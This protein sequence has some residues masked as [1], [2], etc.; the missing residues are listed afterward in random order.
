MMK[1]LMKYLEKMKIFQK[2]R[3]QTI[4]SSIKRLLELE[5]PD[6]EFPEI[7]KSITNLLSDV[8]SKILSDFQI[9]KS[10]PQAVFFYGSNCDT[11]FRPNK[12]GT[13]I[14]INL[15]DKCFLDYVFENRKREQF[16]I[17]AL[18]MLKSLIAEK[19]V[20]S[21][22]GI[23][24]S[25]VFAYENIPPF[26][27]SEIPYSDKQSWFSEFLTFYFR[28]VNED[29][30]TKVSHCFD[31]LHELAHVIEKSNPKKLEKFHQIADEE[32]NRYINSNPSLE[33][34]EGYAK[35]LGWA[36]E[37]PIELYDEL[38]NTN[39]IRSIER[40]PYMKQEVICDLFAITYL[41]Q[42][43]KKMNL[44]Y[45]E[46]LK[47][48]HAKLNAHHLR[49]IVNRVTDQLNLTEVLHGDSK[50]NVKDLDV[51][52]GDI[53]DR[54][55]I[56]TD[57]ML[58]FAIDSGNQNLVEKGHLHIDLV[59]TLNQA[60]LEAFLLPLL[61]IIPNFIIFAVE[62]L[63]NEPYR[64]SMEYFIKKLGNKNLA[65]FVKKPSFI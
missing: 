24:F 49:V 14:C 53:F 4:P 64:E 29:K 25:L 45:W 65:N 59:R 54:T 7:E 32:F 39:K 6:I 34:V 43:S 33:E 18:G 12:N 1:P 28:G 60:Y 57:Y 44:S 47:I 40:F 11:S 30:V 20:Y 10:T 48:I 22:K 26:L 55:R 5:S 17:G 51:Y 41:L 36:E 31:Y 3:K 16:A 15:R 2:N 38:T 19:H 50:L 46:L 52:W 8:T 42:F 23:L 62:K 56:A 13:F 58:S 9:E 61:K 21:K 37:M 35:S 27:L 63:K